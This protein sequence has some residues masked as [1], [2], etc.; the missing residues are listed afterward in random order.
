VREAVLQAALDELVLH[1]YGEFRIERVAERANVHK[2]TVYRQWGDRT[3]LAK[4]A[5][6]QWQRDQTA[7]IDTGSWEG[8]LRALC[9]ELASLEGSEV[10]R[11]LL[12][13]LVVANVVDAELTEAMHEQ[14]APDSAVLVEPILRAQQRGEVDPELDPQLIIEMITGPLVQRVIVMARPIDAAFVDGLVTVILAGTASRR[15]A[16]RRLRPVRA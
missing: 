4:D 6:T 14:W 2:T 8:D 15:A 5:M 16:R 3:A 7:S 10:T 12:R 13:T 1:G 11:A 9:Q